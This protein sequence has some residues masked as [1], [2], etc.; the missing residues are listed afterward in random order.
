M[1]MFRSFI[2]RLALILSTTAVICLFLMAATLGL[3][4]ATQAMPFISMVFG[5]V[6]IWFLFNWLI[7]KK[8]DPEL[9]VEVARILFPSG[10]L[11]SL[12]LSVVLA[13]YLDALIPGTEGRQHWILPFVGI[14]VAIFLVVRCFDIKW[15]RSEIE[16]IT[17]EEK[18]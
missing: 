15:L 11:L 9:S 3:Q 8:V 2:L 7:V 10:A 12:V 17:L 1:R 18:K 13:M 5:I 4:G 14:G 6:L 16:I